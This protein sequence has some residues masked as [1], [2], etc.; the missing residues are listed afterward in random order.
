MEVATRSEIYAWE[1]SG[2]VSGARKITL[3]PGQSFEAV[4]AIRRYLAMLRAVRTCDVVCVGLSYA[5]I[6]A[7]LL[8]WTLRLLGKRVIVF[9]DSKFDDRQRSV[10]FEVLKSIILSCYSGAIV[11][12]RRQL[13]YFRFLGFR[14]R[15]V[16][17]GYD[18]VDVERIRR[19]AG[20]DT[21]VRANFEARP[22]VFV[23]RFVAKKNLF[24]LLAAFAVYAAAAGPTPRRLCLVGGG[25]DEARL[26]QAANELGIGGLVDFPGFLDAPAVARALSGALALVLVSSEEQWGLVVNE[27]LAVGLPVIVSFEVGSRDA[28]VRNL[29]NGF[30]VESN[31]VDSIARAMHEICDRETW[32]RLAAASHQRAWLG[33]CGRLA[34]AIELLVD[35]LS[36][37]AAEGNDRMMAEFAMGRN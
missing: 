36:A 28:L 19:Q 22:F 17:P 29:V 1:P 16:L 25:E 7:I 34:D 9:S 37:T 8:S 6:D 35:P 3:F 10:G 24:T 30:V 2:N 5:Q 18:T 31:N 26:R 32:Q 14:K 21:S 33:D 15:P 4:P 20:D 27:A 12:G 13:D 11:A 23:G